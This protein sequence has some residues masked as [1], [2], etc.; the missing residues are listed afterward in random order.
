MLIPRPFISDNDWRYL[1]TTYR[2]LENKL[3]NNRFTSE[4]EL[5]QVRDTWINACYP[6]PLGSQ[7]YWSGKSITFR[8]FNHNC[9][10]IEQS[11]TLT[12]SPRS[13]SIPETAQI[14]YY[15]NFAN[16]LP[17]F[18][19][20]RQE[21]PQFFHLQQYL[22]YIQDYVFLEFNRD[23]LSC[24]SKYNLPNYYVLADL[25]VFYVNYANWK[26]WQS[27]SK[28]QYEPFY[29]EGTSYI[30]PSQ[31]Y[32]YSP[33][34]LSEEYAES[35]V[36]S[37]CQSL[38]SDYLD[39]FK[40]IVS[41]LTHGL[42][43]YQVQGKRYTET[44]YYLITHFCTGKGFLIPTRIFFGKTLDWS[45]ESLLAHSQ[46]IP[47]RKAFFDYVQNEL[48]LYLTDDM[49]IPFSFYLAVNISS[50]KD[51]SSFAFSLKY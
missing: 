48:S 10:N 24:F 33:Q 27:D 26:Y 3:I 13:F 38:P 51:F 5:Q 35:F 31:S 28:E 8:Y 1:A 15:Q 2:Y 47:I 7:I 6:F 36:P 44:P 21:H 43:R 23:D 45:D 18:T 49:S 25:P 4:T 46:S 32:S 29:Y 19:R 16:R 40:T 41:K 20:L 37:I 11:Q 12:I 17:K 42:C 34:K 22:W 14:S 30:F 39:K 9:Q 50:V